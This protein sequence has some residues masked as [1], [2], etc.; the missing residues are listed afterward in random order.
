LPPPKAPAALTRCSPLHRILRPGRHGADR[1]EGPG[2]TLAL[3]HPVSIVTII[4]RKDKATDVSDAMEKHFGL[5]CP[6]AGHST[7]NGGLSL[8]WCGFE[9][10]YAVSDGFADGALYEAL[11]EH[12]SGLASVSDQSHGR[13][14]LHIEGPRARDVLAK[15]TALDL[16]PRAFGPGRSAVTQMAHVGVHIAQVGPDAFELSLFRGFA[17][18]F[19]EWLTEM[20]GEY[21]YEVR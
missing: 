6:P 7:S 14:I 11:R 1:P 12:L 5:A 10:W 8:H 2:V 17:I 15:G 19:W 16:H 3:R 13:V 9:Q 20:S 18:S 21:G 4:A